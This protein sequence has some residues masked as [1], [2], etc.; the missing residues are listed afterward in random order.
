VDLIPQHVIL[1]WL[2]GFLIFKKG[3]KMQLTKIIKKTEIKENFDKTQDY[4][5][6]IYKI[7]KEK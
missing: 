3:G 2:L 5:D 6:D 4:K 7:M 1:T